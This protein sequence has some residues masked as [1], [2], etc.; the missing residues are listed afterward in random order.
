MIGF[1]GRTF[2]MVLIMALAAVAFGAGPEA[3]A[4]VARSLGV[5]VG[6]LVRAFQ[7]P[8][9][10]TVP[11]GTPAPAPEPADRWDSDDTTLA[12]IMALAG[13]ALA[14]VP[15]CGYYSA[16]I[17]RWLIRLTAIP[18][19]RR[20]AREFARK[21]AEHEREVAEAQYRQEVAE[22]EHDVTDYDM[23]PD[24]WS[25]PA[26]CRVCTAAR[27]AQAIIGEA[28]TVRPAASIPSLSQAVRNLLPKR[29]NR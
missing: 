26:E 27:A 29:V 20:E 21:Q 25:H 15:I 23:T 6:S 4:T 14:L 12:I 13:I 10:P 1:L 9:I 16:E 22:L 3:S 28:G 7:T 19:A 17:R 2:A 24:E 8:E 11:A 5:A 18:A